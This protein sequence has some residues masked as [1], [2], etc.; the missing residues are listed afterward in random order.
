MSDVPTQMHL[1]VMGV[2]GSGKSTVG[3]R[4]ADELGADFVDADD[5]HP[6]ENKERMAAGL[7]LRDSDRWP[8]LRTVGEHLA[9]APAGMVVA[10][11]ALRRSYRDALRASDPSVFFIHLAGPQE[12]VAQRMAGRGHEFMPDSLLASQYA[13][14]EALG[15]DE[16]HLVVDLLATPDEIAREVST[17]LEKTE[18]L[19]PEIS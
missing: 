11:S 13:T 10:C 6:S 9:A 18:F 5:L 12:L 2:S 7:P 19:A 3:K 16:P 8:W 1:V 14:L 15:G 17:R 4:I